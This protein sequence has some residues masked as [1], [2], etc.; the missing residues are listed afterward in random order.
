MWIHCYHILTIIKNA[1]LNLDADIYQQYFCFPRSRIAVSWVLS[2]I[3]DF[4]E[5]TILF[6]V[7]TSNSE[8]HQ[9]CPRVAS[10]YIFTSICYCCFWNEPFFLK[11]MRWYLI[12][13][14]LREGRREI[15]FLATP[16]IFSC[17]L[18]GTEHG[19]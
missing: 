16:R 12:V 9:Q 4:W 17:Q 3:F 18:L 1:A 10:L 7:V 6:S 19:N 8:S 15:P 5:S 2:S 11:A 14:F 13:G